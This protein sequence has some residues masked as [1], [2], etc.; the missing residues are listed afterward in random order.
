MN[1]HF[2][3]PCVGCRH[4][5]VWIAIASD[6]ETYEKLDPSKFTTH[7]VYNAHVAM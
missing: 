7:M 3:G 5:H 2:Q 4:D 1:L 6:H